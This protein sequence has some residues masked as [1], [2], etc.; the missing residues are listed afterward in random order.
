LASTIDP[1]ISERA[2]ALLREARNLTYQWTHELGAK[3]DSTHD[4]ASRT[5]LRHRLCTL[6]ATC[7]STFDVSSEHL[8]ATLASDEDF[9]IAMHCA[10][11]VRD[12]TPPR[13]SDDNFLYLFRMLS[14]HRRLLHD[15]EPI[16]SE[17]LPTAPDQLRRSGAYNQALGRL[18]LGYCPPSDSSWRALPEP[19]SRWI[20][21]LTKGGK[22]VHYN[23]LTGQLLIDGKPL[24]RLPQEIV[25]HRTYQSVLGSVGDQVFSFLPS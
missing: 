18:W 4:E 20:F 15:L 23:L 21:H 5:S 8:P 12:N 1:V 9:S 11:I 7:F 17:S 14:R 24:G 16:F 25:E 13:L 2:S 6:A 10:C 19:N 22:E 3:L